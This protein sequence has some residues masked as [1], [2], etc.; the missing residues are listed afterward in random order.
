[1]NP[2]L[3]L[4]HRK[5]LEVGMATESETNETIKSKIKAAQWVTVISWLTY[6][7]EPPRPHACRPASSPPSWRRRRRAALRAFA[8]T[9][10]HTLAHSPRSQQPF[11]YIIPMFGAQ[12]AN[13]VVGI[14]VGY[15][16][17]DIISKCG[18]GMLIYQITIAKSQAVKNNPDN[19]IGN[20]HG[21]E[22]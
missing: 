21:M 6:V 20:G 4:R 16:M 10:S 15:C 17:S 14:Q 13:A 3:I 11:V 22:A 19:L 7:R 9:L 1:M 2:D 18:V 5:A 8:S 12:G